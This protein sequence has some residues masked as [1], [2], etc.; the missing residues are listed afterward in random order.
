MRCRIATSKTAPAAPRECLRVLILSVRQK[1][2]FLTSGTL[3]S[4]KKL[5]LRSDT[6]R[7]NSVNVCSYLSTLDSASFPSLTRSLQKRGTICG[8]H[9]AS[10]A[11]APSLL[12]N[13]EAGKGLSWRECPKLMPRCGFRALSQSNF[14]LMLSRRAASSLRV[15][16]VPR[17][18]WILPINIRRAMLFRACDQLT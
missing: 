15:R 8:G 7:S 12:Q 14:Q 13:V 3:M 5:V 16:S 10:E 9:S 4:R 6:K 18:A 2:K 11:V 17:T 1:L